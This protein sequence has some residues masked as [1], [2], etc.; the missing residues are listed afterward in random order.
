MKILLILI[1]LS[2]S[3][4]LLEAGEL[5]SISLIM[6]IS[7]EKKPGRAQNMKSSAGV[8]LGDLVGMTDLGPIVKKSIAPHG[9]DLAKYFP[10]TE[11]DLLTNDL[12]FEAKRDIIGYYKDLFGKIKLNTLNDQK[13]ITANKF[14]GNKLIGKIADRILQ[15]EG[16]KE[17]DRRKLWVDKILEPFN[18]CMASAKNALYAADYCMDALKSSLVPSVG[19]GV[20][21]E[22]SRSSLVS[23][24]SK[25]Q[26][27][28]FYNEQVNVY[29]DCIKKA[30]DPA[31]E[32]KKCVLSAM[33]NGIIKITDPKLS[34]I[35]NESASSTT[36]AKT[37]RLALWPEFTICTQKVGSNPNEQ[38]GPDAQFMECI[39][40]LIQNTGSLLVQ[41]KVSNNASVKSSFTKAEIEKLALEKAQNF[42]ECIGDQKKKNNRKEGMLDTTKCENLI[43]NDVT[44]KVVVKSLAKTAS[45]S[46]KANNDVVTKIAAEGKRLLDLCWNNDQPEKER[47][48]CLRKT[49]ISFSQAIATAKLDKVVPNDIQ[50]KKELT[51]SALKEL[52]NCLQQNLPPN[53]SQA[54]NLNA[55]TSFCSNKLTLKVAQEVAQE[56]VY[57]KALNQKLSEAEALN[58]VTTLV[59]QN[60]LS[61]LGNNP[62]DSKLDECVGDLTKSAT[63]SIVLAYEK[64]QI[65][66][67]LNA[68]SIPSKLK[69]IE[70]TFIACTENKYSADKVSMAMDECIKDF[71]LG[72]ARNLGDLKFNTLLKSVLGTQEYNEQKKNI[73][74]ILEKY[75]ECLDDLEKFSMKDGLVD[76]LN[77]CTEG[78]ERRGV[79]FV[80]NTVNSWMSTEQKDAVTIMVKNEFANFLPCLSGLLPA[81]PYTQKLEENIVSTLKPVALLIA[82]YIEYSPENAKR[83][84]DEISRKLS[85]DLKDVASNPASR[86]E[87]IDMLYTNGALDQFLKSMVHNQV[88]ESFDTIPESELSAEL[89]ASLLDKNNFDKIFSTKEGIVIKDMIMEKILSPVLME[90]A[91]LTSP[92]MVAGMDSVKDR[93]VKMLVYSPNFGEQIVRTSV[94][95]QIN[96]MG[97]LARFFAKVIYGKNALDWEKVRMTSKGKQAEEFIMTSV[98]L[99][100]FKGQNFSAEEEKKN[101]EE[102]K[103]LV[104]AAVK[105]YE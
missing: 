18:Q 55:Q 22:L 48:S 36:A 58:L 47:E 5:D 88:K 23:S 93:V 8:W 21:Y 32:T 66:E 73:D 94:Q 43:T 65:K 10:E 27:P 76:K 69:P 78:L 104:T 72:F 6:P 90:Q 7:Y 97:G 39:D 96:E 14:L 15:I 56:S 31:S 105:S 38:L 95:N 102:A 49:I 75:N 82:Q 9:A 1:F 35:I 19:L 12:V 24:L 29:K 99:P 64:K 103:K 87:L 45:D 71:A 60:F 53:I 44:Y 13:A 86:K 41:D 52:S 51:Q 50:G 26:H 25:N 85:T 42:K 28:D 61:C 57:S 62:S 11:L 100:K 4:S 101:N 79:N 70:E 33:K 59:K 30:V 46:F 20:V 68:D 92:L 54:N 77:F 63:K 89:R 2:S 98:L 83:T 17:A 40:S 16:V 84:L 80:S 81:S 34:K 37:I 74:N 67:Q 3:I 91:S